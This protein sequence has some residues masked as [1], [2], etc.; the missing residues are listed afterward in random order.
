MKLSVIQMNSGEDKEKNLDAAES[1]V[2]A[3][4]ESD[5]P[6]II[7]LPEMFA[8]L[9]ADPERLHASAENFQKSAVLARI[10]RLARELG[11]FL[12]MGSIIEQD[13]DRY[14]N[15]SGVFNRSGAF[16]AKYRKIHRF[17]VTLPDGT[18][19]FESRIV[20]RGEEVVD[21]A[22]DTLKVG[23]TICY[24]IRFPELF[25]ELSKRGVDLIMAPSAF[26]FPTGADHWEVL[27]RARAIETQCYVAAPAQVLSF[28][29][30][31]YQTWGHAMIVDPWGQIVAQASNRPGW[32]SA[33]I[34]QS[35]L[36]SVRSR[37]QTGR[38]HVL[39]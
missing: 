10:S 7:A 35:W 8:C 28:G 30:G 14:F 37:L 15:T 6:D 3:A 20:G 16:I 18:E 39:G 11:V 12:H 38:H 29:G 2:R 34:D 36:D 17:D 13:G 25:R 23:C 19:L 31:K 33:S 21:Y 5:R 26:T 9:A 4:V 22:A 1:L 24:D 27:L 32:A